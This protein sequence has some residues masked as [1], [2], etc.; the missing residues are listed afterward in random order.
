MAQRAD[1]FK[2]SSGRGIIYICVMDSAKGHCAVRITASCAF[3]QSLPPPRST[4]KGT[5]YNEN[6]QQNVPF[7]KA[8]PPFWLPHMVPLL[9]CSTLGV[10]RIM[11]ISS[12]ACSRVWKLSSTTIQHCILIFGTDVLPV[13]FVCECFIPIAFHFHTQPVD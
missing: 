3:Q 12:M 1:R 11:L 5:L 9:V 8:H 13:M 4:L 7:S 2:V 6:R 10:S